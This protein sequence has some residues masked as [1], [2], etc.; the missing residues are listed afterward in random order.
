MAPA[1]SIAEGSTA[2]DKLVVDA[3]TRCPDGLLL[4]ILRHA[5]LPPRYLRISRTT[6]QREGPFRRNPGRAP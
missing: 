4:C 5:R 3:R 6:P 1:A 2:S